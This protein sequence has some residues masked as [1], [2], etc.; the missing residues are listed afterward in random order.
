MTGKRESFYD[1]PLVLPRYYE[2]VCR[3]KHPPDRYVKRK[4]VSSKSGL[5]N[6]LTRCWKSNSVRSNR[7]G[8][9]HKYGLSLDRKQNGR[10]TN[11]ST[12]SMTR[13]LEH[14]NSH[15]NMSL[16]EGRGRGPVCV[17][18]SQSF[19]GMSSK[20]SSSSSTPVLGDTIKRTPRVYTHPQH[21]SRNAGISFR[22]SPKVP[23]V[24]R[25]NRALLIFESVKKGLGEFI[26]AT[27]E[28]M[29]HLQ[30]NDSTASQQIKSAERYL[31]KLEFH[32]AKV[33]ELYDCYLVHQQLREG[34][35]TMAR[36]FTTSPG[37]RKDSITNVKYGYKECSQTLC[38]IEAQLE[39]M[40]GTFHCKLKGMAGFA[41]LC[42]GD[43]F[44]VTIRHGPQKWKTKG[45]IEKNNTQ[46]WDMPEFTFKALVGDVLSIKALESRSFKSVLL[47][48]KN[49]E[50]KDL[51]SA[52]P[53]LMTISINF[54][55]SL[56]LSI[57]ITWNPLEGM[58]ESITFFEA[59]TRSAT[60]PRRRPVSV[61]ALNGQYSNS[62]SDLGH[63]RRYSSPIHMLRSKEDFSVFG[64][65]TSLPV[66]RG[67][68][69]SPS[70]HSPLLR[71][72]EN[73]VYSSSDESHSSLISQTVL[74]SGAL[75]PPIV[76]QTRFP[77]VFSQTL[78]TRDEPTHVEEALVN[79]TTS[80]EDFLGQY[81]E[82]QYL[83]EV[84][85]SL[86]QFL[87]KRSRCSSRSSSI[88]VSI[89]SALEAFDFLNTEE[90]VEDL[91]HSPEESRTSSIDNILVSP[92]ST[93][94]TGDSGIESLA[95]RLS[96]DTQLGSSL[97]SSPV[98]PST[99]NEQVDHALLFHLN[100]C[101]RLLES[102]GNFGPL[103][104]REFY[105][106]DK[107]KTQSGIIAALLKIAR[108]GPN[109]DLHPI[110]AELTDDKSIKEF[111]VMCVDQNLLFLHPEKLVYMMEQKFGQR[112]QDAANI[113]PTRAFWHVM[114]KILDIP[115]Y[116][117]EK[118]KSSHIVTLHQF[119]SYFTSAGG[120]QKL[121]DVTHDIALTDR[122]CSGNP[123]I[124]IKSILT[125][126]EELP[127]P[128]C[129]KVIGSLLCG[130]VNKEIQ[131][132]AAS[133]LKLVS[134]NKQTR[135]KA[136]IVFVE[137]LEDMLPDVRA[138][139]CMALSVIEA[140]ECTDQLVFVCQSDDSTTVRRK[141]KDAL[142][143]LG[144]EGRK[145]F[146]ETQLTTHG[147]QGLQMRK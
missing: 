121:D 22:K 141:A 2:K 100:Y 97:G 36:A 99:G 89:E 63:E 65:S 103:K 8:T 32:L 55:G 13:I 61:V 134:K 52:N 108:A 104:C 86:E 109:V 132:S 144:D 98:P 123:D 48:Q 113:S 49:C 18:R 7:R 74:G 5:R 125:Q 95:K 51:F 118:L 71:V 128:L 116:Q 93:A 73:T 31:K 106:L 79:L 9:S 25:P 131:Q 92:E 143:S 33:D 127:S 45:R 130:G 6:S 80:M 87:R 117:P 17:T 75:S 84:V 42:P 96:E 81:P 47:G 83:E 105:A 59:P 41:R 43:V 146:E 70:Y 46:K 138:G 28:D 122:L 102:L 90:S 110:M 101:D 35:R 54:N 94:K 60:T 53:Q 26:H 68:Y 115:T 145:A 57:V 126:R 78:V 15:D 62:Y 67:G 19:G 50:V 82:L 147:F 135:D 37:H 44:E 88:S 72:K 38:A 139:S 14:D 69:D 29:L 21:A 112:L 4:V 114:S 11:H 56:K 124:V 129:L 137:G 20:S 16:K 140:V 10:P 66:V 39:N 119:M 27:K 91:D 107:L 136:M 77:G 58:D 34:A 76:P 64:S 1:E 142:F 40:L 24:P 23:K 3:M 12:S 30:T 120:L 133:Y 85:V 111:W